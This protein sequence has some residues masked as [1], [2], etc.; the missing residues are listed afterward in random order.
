MCNDLVRRRRLRQN[1]HLNQS[2]LV[3]KESRRLIFGIQDPVSQDTSVSFEWCMLSGNTA[4]VVHAPIGT[5]GPN[6][7]ETGL[8]RSHSTESPV[9]V[10]QV[11]QKF[12][13]HHVQANY[14]VP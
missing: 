2:L 7:A 5:V 12:S 6:L 1:N 3:H 11:S 8:L 14:R 4:R 13:L 9:Y 10:R